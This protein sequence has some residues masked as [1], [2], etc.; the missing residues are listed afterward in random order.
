[1]A[2]TGSLWPQ[3]SGLRIQKKQVPTFAK[4]NM[5]SI[6]PACHNSC[7]EEPAWHQVS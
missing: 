4:D 1:M 3:V 7:D 5:A 2:N 6:Q